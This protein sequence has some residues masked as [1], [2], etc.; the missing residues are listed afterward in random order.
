MKKSFL[1][2]SLLFAAS[3]MLV[4]QA[5][6]QLLKRLKDKVSDKIENKVDKA[7][8]G[9]ISSKTTN[10]A[11]NAQTTINQKAL[12]SAELPYTF[13]QG[14]DSIYF[15]D[16]AA[17]ITGEMASH[18]KS[19][20]SGSIGT[21]ST[22][23]GKWLFLKEFTSY[24]L[25]NDQPLPED[26]TVEFDIITLSKG[27][28]RDLN[29]ISFG[30]A[31][32][33]AI[34]NYIGDAYNEGAITQTEIHYWNKEII[35]SSSD[36][37]KYNT[38]KFPLEGYAIGKMHVAVTVKKLHMQVYLDK[39]KVLDTDMFAS[40]PETKYFYISTSTNLDNGARIGVGN[41]KIAGL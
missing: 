5:Q 1:S 38:I 31:H 26:F 20:G 24:K 15:D 40:N 22:F 37:K 32:N 30:F 3:C 9:D 4:N 25:K 29:S 35:N 13:V 2:L 23:P 8:D 10:G 18:W 16:F 12:A 7:L 39:E 34:S 14:T 27:E 36:N 33:N 21:V 17:D 6:A 19:S 41:F 28:A 11:D